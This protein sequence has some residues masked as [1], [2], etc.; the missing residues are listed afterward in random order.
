MGKM[1]NRQQCQMP[2]VQKMLV[3]HP[4]MVSASYIQAWPNNPEAFLRLK[5]TKI[6]KWQEAIC[7]K[8][9]SIM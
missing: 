5:E 2:T 3:S 6:L 9:K 7:K 8:N 4:I 1:L